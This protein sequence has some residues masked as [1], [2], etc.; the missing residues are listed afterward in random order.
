[1]S[2]LAG[3]YQG[4]QAK[5]D[6]KEVDITYLG[7]EGLVDYK[8][9]DNKSVSMN[10]GIGLG[11][12]IPASKSSNT[13]DTSKI[14]MSQTVIGSISLDW[15]LRGHHFIPIELNYALYPANNTTSANQIFLKIG[16]GSGF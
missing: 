6:T 16:Y 7:F 12:L 13:I 8:F 11:F 9:I 10:A 15:K 14:F 5:L 3:S 2:S 1:M 4:M